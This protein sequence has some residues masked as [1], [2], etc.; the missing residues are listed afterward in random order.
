MSNVKCD[1]VTQRMPV[2]EIHS[3]D[4]FKSCRIGIAFQRTYNG[5]I[6]YKAGNVGKGLESIAMKEGIIV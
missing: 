5:V 6:F 2:P 3:F 4:Q 1:R